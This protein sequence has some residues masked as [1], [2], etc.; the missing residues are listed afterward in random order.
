[1]T[2]TVIIQYIQ[3]DITKSTSKFG[4]AL[5]RMINDTNEIDKLSKSIMEITFNMVKYG[6]NMEAIRESNPCYYECG[7]ND[8]ANLMRMRDNYS[9]QRDAME[10]QHKKLQ[11]TVFDYIFLAKQV[12]EKYG[13][14]YINH[15]PFATDVTELYFGMMTYM[16]E[17]ED[18]PRI[19]LLASLMDINISLIDY[20]NTSFNVPIS[21]H[22][23]LAMANK[24]VFTPELKE[25]VSAHVDAA[26]LISEDYAERGEPI[27]DWM[28]PSK[29]SDELLAKLLRHDPK[30]DLKRYFKNKPI[31]PSMV[32]KLM[33]KFPDVD[34]TSLM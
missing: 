32:S 6:A 15:L 14:D 11:K 21:H 22:G 13:S 3:P 29:P 5:K 27:P 18:N 12:I 23:A 17:L 7:M 4:V 24:H 16:K 30:C 20:A 28:I 19:D 2:S 25:Y 10:E 26:N 31:K 34:F 8:I 33:Q 1:M 9:E